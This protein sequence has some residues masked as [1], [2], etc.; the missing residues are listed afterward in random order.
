M[1]AARRRMFSSTAAFYLAMRAVNALASVSASDSPAAASPHVDGPALSRGLFESQERD[2]AV[3]G[4]ET[5][6]RA[7]AAGG[8]L[9]FS[10]APAKPS[11]IR[12]VTVSAIRPLRCAPRMLRRP[13]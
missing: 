1:I 4:A 12:P 10:P 6:D 8:K 3:L 2:Q 9:R 5:R 11:R 7:C 13:G